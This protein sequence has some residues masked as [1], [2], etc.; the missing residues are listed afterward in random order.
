M[1]LRIPAVALT[2]REITATGNA[3]LVKGGGYLSHRIHWEAPSSEPY[4]DANS[5]QIVNGRVYVPPSGS[6]TR[7]WVSF[8]RLPFTAEDVILQVFDDV[9][10]TL[11]MMRPSGGFE[12]RSI[13]STS[14]TIAAGATSLLYGDT[15][16]FSGDSVIDDFTTRRLVMPRGFIA[17]GSSG[18]TTFKISILA[19]L[20]WG[21]SSTFANY[22][23]FNVDQVDV[24]GVYSVSYEFG[25]RPNFIATAN[26]H[27]GIA[28][29]PWP[30]C[31]MAIYATNTGAVNNTVE[32]QLYEK[33]PL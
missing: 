26:S 28:P 1:L 20:G 19:R 5:E 23:V 2:V 13:H 12:L 4:R 15:P 14:A 11:P 18:N 17:G 27:V 29:L 32:L 24:N 6:F 3:V 30:S 25:G 21:P 31:G 22:A 16:Y 10:V 9:E 8:E 7:F 33:T